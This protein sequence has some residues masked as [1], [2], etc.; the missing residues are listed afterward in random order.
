MITLARRLLLA[1]KTFGVPFGQPAGSRVRTAA[2]ETGWVRR[3]GI[4]GHEEEV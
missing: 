1:E 3:R 4:S 2:Q